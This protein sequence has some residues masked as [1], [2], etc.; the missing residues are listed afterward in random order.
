M[1]LRKI[2][3]VRSYRAAPAGVREI[4]LS[5]GVSREVQAVASQIAAVANSAGEATYDSRALEVRG[6][7]QNER[8]A[9]ASVYVVK[10]HWRDSRDEILVR[11][12]QSMAIRSGPIDP[13]RKMVTYTRKDGTTRQATAAQAENWMRQRGDALR[14]KVTR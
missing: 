12:A 11:V 10:P 6:G 5:S 14:G 1:E 13:G 8:R 2:P 3:G 4:M 7:W 9:G